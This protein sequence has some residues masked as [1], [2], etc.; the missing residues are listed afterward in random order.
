ML[1]PSLDELH[2]PTRTSPKKSEMLLQTLFTFTAAATTALAADPAPP[3][4]TYLYSV[5]LTF[6]APISIG[7]VPYGTRDL[8]TIS[9]GN[10]AGPKITGKYPSS[11]FSP[12]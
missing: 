10:V 2:S 1:V 8:L 7:S 5:N 11:S 4:L 3:A 6:A 9:G 12:P